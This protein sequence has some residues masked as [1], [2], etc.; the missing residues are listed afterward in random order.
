M[1]LYKTPTQ[2]RDSSE[3][4]G[5]K[6]DRFSEEVEWNPKKRRWMLPEHAR[7]AVTA[8][9]ERQ[10]SQGM[11]WI[12][13]TSRLTLYVRD[14][15]TCSYCRASIMD[16]GNK[17]TLDH[18]IPRSEGGSNHATNLITACKKCNE[19]RGKR[20]VVQ[21]AKDVAVYTQEKHTG[22]LRRINRR[23]KKDPKK[24]RAEA[25]KLMGGNKGSW[26]ELLESSSAKNL[27]AKT[28]KET[29]Y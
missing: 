15:F 29:P 27:R 16:N 6:P 10:R 7:D 13:K 26:N 11:N 2:D 12:S 3:P 22:I 17:L 28:K 5:P 23:V 25:R 14:G 4:P 8:R 19:V 20:G 1:L 24:A 21:F 9:A 18:V